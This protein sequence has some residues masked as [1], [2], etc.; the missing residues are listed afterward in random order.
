MHTKSL[1]FT[2]PKAIFKKLYQ[3]TTQPLRFKRVEPL[4]KLKEQIERV[5]KEVG[6]IDC[7]FSNNDTTPPPQAL[8]EEVIELPETIYTQMGISSIIYIKEFQEILKLEDKENLLSILDRLLPL[9]S[10]TKYIITGSMVNS[11]KYIFEEVKYL[12]NFAKRV[13]LAPLLVDDLTHH[14]QKQ[15]LKTGRVISTELASNIH[16]L[17][18][19]HPWYAQQLGEIAYAHTRGFL[20]HD[21]L[22]DSFDSLL[23]LHSYRYQ[24]ITSNLSRYQISFLKAVLDGVSLFSSSQVIK[25]YSLRSSANVKRQKESFKKKEIL[26][27]EGGKML[28]LDPLFKIWLKEHYFKF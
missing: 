3:C 14:F 25:E 15:F 24:I 8:I 23:Q 16:S 28:F 7:H 26:T 19:G 22:Q 17:V 4:P 2:H 6:D 13:K 21:I 5:V 1:Q 18:E 9:Q 12:Y 27:E 11:M 20:T 10:N